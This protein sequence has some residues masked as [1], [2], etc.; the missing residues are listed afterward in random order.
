MTTMSMELVLSAYRAQ[1][2]PRRLERLAKVVADL[3]D[4]IDLRNV[5]QL[6]DRK[7]TLFVVWRSI[8]TPKQVQAA[9]VA[10][11]SQ[12]EVDVRHGIIDRFG[13]PVIEPEGDFWF[14]S[15]HDL[16]RFALD[17]IEVGEWHRSLEE[18][19]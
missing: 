9:R 11:E 7:G 18:A 6:H 4:R 17:R 10:W 2:E 1:D 19:P 13:D 5:R 15:E 8:P 12:N 3:Q 14:L 16:I